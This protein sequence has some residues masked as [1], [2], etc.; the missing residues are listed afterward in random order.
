MSL[1]LLDDEN[2]NGKGLKLR[3]EQIYTGRKTVVTQDLIKTVRKYKNLGVPVTEIARINRKSR[4]TIYK[5]LKEE[6]GYVSNRL[7]KPE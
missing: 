4:S 6:L 7:I 2:I 3:R 5:V 1:K